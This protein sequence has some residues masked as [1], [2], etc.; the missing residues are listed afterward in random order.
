MNFVRKDFS[1]LTKV[2]QRSMAWG[3]DRTPNILV[4][5]VVKAAAV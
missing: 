1:L 5:T 2:G 3:A 4:T